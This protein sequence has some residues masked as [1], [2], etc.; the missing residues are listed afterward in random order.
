[1]C[2][3][4]MKTGKQVKKMHTLGIKLYLTTITKLTAPTLPQAVPA[5]GRMCSRVTITITCRVSRRQPA[6]S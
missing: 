4:C 2:V 6:L 5:H 1:M 3:Y